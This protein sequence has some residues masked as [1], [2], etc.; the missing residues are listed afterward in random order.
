MMN[1]IIGLLNVFYAILT[2]EGFKKFLKKY[3]KRIEE[4]TSKV[5]REERISESI[6]DTFDEL[7]KKEM[8][9][10]TLLNIY[11]GLLKG[12]IDEKNADKFLKD[13]GY[14][15]NPNPIKWLKKHLFDLRGWI[16]DSIKYLELV[17]EK[18]Q[19]KIREIEVEMSISPKVS[20]IF[21]PI[22]H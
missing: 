9:M 15:I 21:E 22:K 8:E 20:M 7:S 4:E 17:G 13:L 3:L 10:H 1:D 19:F 12:E 18:S 6:N 16:I 2:S 11:C 5:K 14:K